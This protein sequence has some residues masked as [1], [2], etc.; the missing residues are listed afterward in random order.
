[1]K[2]SN[3]LI[4]AVIVVVSAFLLWLWY[5]L[6]FNHVDSPLDLV[7][8]VVWW[9]I[10]VVGVV[11]VAKA[12]KTRQ[13]SVRTVYLGEGRLYNSETGVRMLS[14]GASVADSLA[15]VLAGLTYGFDR[16]AAPDPNDEEN[17]ANWTHVVRTSKYEPARTDEDGERKDETW[18]G[19]VVVVETGKAIPFDSRERLATI[20]G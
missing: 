18:E 3:V 1:M 9:A 4:T 2:K 8:S 6:G 11:L 17:P 5:N 19:E 10:V 13:E 15:A 12:E 14:A 16:E 20:I 7:L